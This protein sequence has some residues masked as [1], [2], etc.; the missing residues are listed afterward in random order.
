MSQRAIAAAQHVLAKLRITDPSQIQI[1]EIAY[2][3]NVLTTEKE[4]SGSEGRLVSRNGKAILTVKANLHAARRRFVIAHEV[5]HHVLHSEMGLNLC[6][7]ADFI[8]YHKTRPQESE[9]N[10]FASEILMPSFLWKSDTINGEPSWHVVENYASYFS[11]SFT[12]TCIKYINMFKSPVTLIC[13]ENGKIKW[14]FPNVSCRYFHKNIGESI[15]PE[16]LAN[17]QTQK[18]FERFAKEIVLP[19]TWFSDYNL[20][21][22]QYF[23]ESC[24][25]SERYR[26]TLSLV[27]PMNF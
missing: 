11:T 3:E 20:S 12:A 8:G 19:R 25:Y 9:A 18:A 26:Q 15:S 16:S 21:D 23:Y 14:F 17:K 6:E 4:I 13:S 1:E 22:D 2:L 27:W 5:G 24:Y 10:V 7:S